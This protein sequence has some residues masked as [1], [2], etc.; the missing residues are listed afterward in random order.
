MVNRRTPNVAA[1]SFLPSMGG[2][3][4]QDPGRSRSSHKYEMWREQGPLDRAAAS[5]PRQ[6]LHFRI[7]G[8]ASL[9]GRPRLGRKP[10][11]FACRRPPPA[12]PAPPPRQSWLNTPGETTCL[13]TI[14][15]VG[16]STRAPVVSQNPPLPFPLHTTTRHHIESTARALNLPSCSAV[17]S[18]CVRPLQALDPG[19]P[20][21]QHDSPQL[22]TS[23]FPPMVGFLSFPSCVCSLF[24][25]LSFLLER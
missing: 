15:Q 6:H 3:A 8:P 20:I 4:L 5:E 14:Y 10:Q 21:G 24:S 16:A 13:A 7:A 23:P 11:A 18:S 17:S 9:F 1:I 12:A 19:H 22:A 2:L 25:F